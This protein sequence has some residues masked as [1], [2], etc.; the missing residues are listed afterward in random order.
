M[1]PPRRQ[2]SRREPR[3]AETPEELRSLERA[4]GSAVGEG[5][6]ADQDVDG[7][8]ELGE[9]LAGEDGAVGGG[10]EPDVHGWRGSAVEGVEQDLAF[11]RGGSG[12]D[13]REVAS[14]SGVFGAVVPAPLSCRGVAAGEVTAPVRLGHGPFRPLP[15][16]DVLAAPASASGRRSSPSTAS[17]SS[18]AARSTPH[19][20]GRPATRRRACAASPGRRPRGHRQPGPAP[21]ARARRAEPVRRR[22]PR[23]RKH[24][25]D[26]LVLE[27]IARPAGPLVR[28]PQARDLSPRR[29]RRLQDDD[30]GGTC[31]DAPPR[32]ML[33]WRWR[34]RWDLN[35]HKAVSAVDRGLLTNL[36]F[37]RSEAM[38]PKRGDRREPLQSERFRDFCDQCVTS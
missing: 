32:R 30:G 26:R 6:R 4:G 7:G 36:Y 14:G 29:G 22:R 28:P 17:S 13:V 31:R 19:F 38:L 18:T 37:R 15:G 3:F 23:R 16:E 24:P 27:H 10:E 33:G 8:A 35:S 12:P 5:R 1:S 9:R 11:G 25:Q 2:R 20:T 34:W 21:Q